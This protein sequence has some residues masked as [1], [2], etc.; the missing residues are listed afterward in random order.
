M[1][2]IAVMGGRGKELPHRVYDSRIG[3]VIPE[4]VAC[5]VEEADFRTVAMSPGG[6]WDF[7]RV[8]CQGSQRRGMR[9]GRMGL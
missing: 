5:E 7:C 2:M 9:A 4:K 8:G 1:Q 3:I 6:S